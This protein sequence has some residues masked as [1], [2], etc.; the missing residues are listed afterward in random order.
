VCGLEARGPGGP[1][2]GG[3][4]SFLVG[5]CRTGTDFTFRP[6]LMNPYKL[7]DSGYG[8]KLEQFGN[9]ILERP[10]SLCIWKR[11][12]PGIWKQADAVY[13]PE[14]GWQHKKEP[15]SNWSIAICD[16]QLELALQSNGQ[17]GLFPEHA[18]YIKSL[19]EDIRRIKEIKG[20]APSVLNLFAYTGMASMAALA[21][22]ADVT[23]VDSSKKALDWANKN[24]ELNN[25]EKDKLRLLPDDVLKF[26]SK[27]A[28]RD[29]RYDI[30]LVDPP[31]FSRVSKSQSWAI[32]DILKEMLGAC[33]A[34]LNSSPGAIYFSNHSASSVSIIIKNLLLDEFTN[35]QIQVDRLSIKEENSDRE[36]PA[37]SLLTAR[38]E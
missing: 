14:K 29:N 28:R 7:L 18:L 10:S 20:K 1:C 6:P 16:I 17:I 19:T 36:M 22:G 35:A 33:L 8:A 3:R 15:F 23:H 26:L 32:E 9:R 12:Q 27:E 5:C 34:V 4:F 31:S 21:A 37:G 30:I 24:R 38:F 13:V 25:L 2:Q 11:R